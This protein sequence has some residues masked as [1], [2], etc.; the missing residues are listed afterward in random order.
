[1]RG[2]AIGTGASTATMRS[3]G[4]RAYYT[5]IAS[6]TKT[7]ELNHSRHLLMRADCR[8]RWSKHCHI[9]KSKIVSEPTR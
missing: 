9:T 5:L 3:A 8:H 7:V 1:M 4:G 2:R 6:Y